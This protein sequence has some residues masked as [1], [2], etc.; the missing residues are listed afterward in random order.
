MAPKPC[1]FWELILT[2]YQVPL[3]L[4]EETFFTLPHYAGKLL[5]K[6]IYY[7]FFTGKKIEVLSTDLF[8]WTLAKK[9]F[10]VGCKRTSLSNFFFVLKAFLFQNCLIWKNALSFVVFLKKKR[11]P[12]PKETLLLFLFKLLSFCCINNSTDFFLIH[13]FTLFLELKKL[14][15]S[16]PNKKLLSQRK[17]KLWNFD[18]VGTKFC[19]LFSYRFLFLFFQTNKNNFE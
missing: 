9:T 4:F 6:L 16:L 11:K 7:C 10:F 2:Q 14:N 12:E 17:L 8:C 1:N 15:P 3:F 18:K 13:D 5:R 19:P